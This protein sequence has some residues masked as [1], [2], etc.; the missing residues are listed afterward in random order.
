MTSSVSITRVKKK[1]GNFLNVP[2]MHLYTHIICA[3]YVE[4]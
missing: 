3:H 1:G 4:P 2:R